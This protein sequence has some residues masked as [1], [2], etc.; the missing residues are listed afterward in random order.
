ML[1]PSIELPRRMNFDPIRQMKNTD[2]PGKTDVYRIEP[3]ELTW[4]VPGIVAVEKT[5]QI[6]EGEAGYKKEKPTRN[7]NW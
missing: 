7:K 6:A 2:N 4:S 3:C 1:W 5:S